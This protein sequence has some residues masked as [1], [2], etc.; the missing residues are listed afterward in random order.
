MKISEALA[1]FR[2][3]AME[4]KPHLLESYPGVQTSFKVARQ[5]LADVRD[6]VESLGTSQTVPAVGTAVYLNNVPRITV[7]PT[8]NIGTTGNPYYQFVYWRM[9]RIQD[10]GGGVNVMDI[11]FRFVNCLTA[12]LAYYL[13]L[14]VPGG[15]D[16]LAILKQQYD[17]AWDLAAQEDQEKAAVRFV[18]R[19]QYIAGS[20]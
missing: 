19:R 3:Y 11:P 7:W 4:D 8:P 14:K 6:G 18:P 1:L 15:M 20:F 2:F 10:A 5:W 16:R 12:G 13:A 9:R 17:E